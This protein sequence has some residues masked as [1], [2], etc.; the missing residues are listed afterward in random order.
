[1]LSNLAI[2]DN[3]V[4]LFGF[5]FSMVATAETDNITSKDALPFSTSSRAVDLLAVC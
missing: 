1:M 5:S 3:A 4:A 2:N